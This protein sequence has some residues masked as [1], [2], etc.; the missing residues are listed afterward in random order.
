MKITK[1]SMMLLSCCIANIASAQELKIVMETRLGNLDPILSASH[2]TREHGYMIYDTLFA[3]DADGQT[4]PQMIDKFQLSDDKMT[5]IFTLRDGLAFH[6]G[7]LV[8]SADVVA[9]IKRWGERDRMGIAV[10]QLTDSVN[11]TDDKTFTIKLNTPTNV[12]I[13]A[14]AKPSGVP[15]FIM[16]AEVAA[17]PVTEAITDYTGSGPF[18]FDA[19]Q[20]TPGV[21]SVYLKNTEYKP[22]SEAPSGLAGGKVAKV[23]QITRIEM[24]DPLTAVNA[25]NEG[26]IDFVQAVPLELAPLV[27]ANENRTTAHLDKSGYQYSYR[28][29]FLNAPFD[30]KLVRQAALEAIGQKD[31]LAAQYGDADNFTVCGAIFGCGTPYASDESAEIAIEAN[32]EKAK[33]LLQKAGYKGEKVLILNVT[34]NPAMA[35]VAPVMAQQMRAAGFNVELQ[36]MDFMTMLSR[37]AS[38][39]PVEKG[40]WSIF[41]TSW[42]V[43]EISDPIRSFMILADGREGYAGWGDVPA[44]QENIK[45]FLLEPDLEKRKEIATNIQKIVYDEGIYA[46]LGQSSRLNGWTKNIDGLIPNGPTVFWNVS[47]TGE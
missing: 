41:I 39:E 35:A 20:Y 18:R 3:L 34:D 11:A 17:T 14:F 4:Q 2:Q 7:K 37:R 8:T 31:V 40:G 45:A 16:P 6:N 29:N 28:L 36:A 15:L 26:E 27:E 12:F 42:Q 21:K 19:A 47:K 33:E 10:M 5:Y 9:S 1:L 44:I 24:P 23:D 22:R 38:K 13:D 32:P 30:N 46:P 43:P 25:L